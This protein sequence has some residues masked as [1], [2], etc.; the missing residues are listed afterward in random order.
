MQQVFRRLTIAIAGSLVIAAMGGQAFASSPFTL[1]PQRYQSQ[2]TLQDIAQLS[3][4][5]DK[6]SIIILRGQHPELPAR[7]TTQGTRASTITQEQAPIRSELAR[8]HA[9][10]VRSFH[11]VNAVAA[12]ISK[13]EID[14]L[15]TNPAVQA[16]VPDLAIPRA[17][18][19]AAAPAATAGKAASAADLQQLCPSDPATP[20]LEPEALQ[21]MNVEFQPGSGQPAAH[22]LADGTGVRV[23]WIADGID[24]NNPDFQ[25]NGHSIFFDYQDFSGEGPNSPTG[26]A[27]AFGD[28]ASIAAQGSQVYDLS[29]FVNPAHPL[30]PGCTIKIKGVA[31]GAELVGLKTFGN[32]TVPFASLFLQAI[33]WAVNVDNVDVINESFGANVYPDKANDPIALADTAAVA[34]GVTVVVSSGDAGITSTIGTPSDAPGVIGVGA[35]TTLRI[36]RQTTS[37][38]GQLVAGGWISDNIS[39]ISSGGFTQFGPHTVD[40][41]APGD[42]GWSLCSTNRATFA[43]CSDLAGRPTNIQEFG[44]TSQSSPLTAGTAALVIQA[45]ERTHGG[46]R[47]SPDL[48]KRIIVSSATDLGV[49]ASE[50]G[51]GLVDALKAVQTALSIHDANGAPAAMGN[52]LVANQTRLSATA[53]AGTSQ[54]FHVRV[55]NTGAVMQ[56]VRPTVQRLADDLLS[57]DTG[58]LTI[59]P[60]TAPTFV[61]Q[62][63]IPS[64]FVVH[65]FSVP[66]GAQRL[67]GNV[68]WD[69]QSQ[70]NS[71]VRLSVFDPFGRQAIYSLPQGPGGFGHV[72]VRNPAAGIW[73][74]VFWTRKNATV[75]NGSFQFS[76]TTQRFERIGSVSPASRTLA[77]G[78]SATFNVTVRLPVQPGDLS[79][80]LALS[81]GGATDGSIPITLRSLVPLG[82][83]GGAFQGTLTGGNGRMAFGAQTFTFQFDVPRGKSSLDLA[84]RL[85]DPNTNVVGLLVDPSG[86]PLDI[87]TT[88]VGGTFTD[89]MQFFEK[90]PRAGRW[91]AVLNLVNPIDGAHLQEPFSGQITFTG[92]QVLTSGVPHSSSTVIPAGKSVTATVQITNSGVSQKDF[93]VDPRLDQK[94]PLPLLGLNPTTV[95]LPILFGDPQPAF[96]V[97]TDSD[98]FTVVANGSV[99]IQ[100]DVSANFG[101]PD[102][103]GVTVG[104][105]SVARHAAREVAPGVWF[106]LPT[107]IGPFGASGA[108]PAVATVGAAVNTRLFDTSVTSTS[109]D[110]WLSS[111]SASAPFSPLTLAPGATGAI[112]VT[113]TPNA[114]R[115][116][117]VRG[118]L[119]IDTFNGATA[120]GDEI[121]VVPDTYRVG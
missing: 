66:S 104:S 37:Y 99:P 97:P 11:V 38:G 27:E 43:N 34:A 60:A 107:E 17:P 87:Q 101:S 64:A 59:S 69:G 21:R 53:P 71:R 108:P 114:P 45:Y 93:F 78:A 79:A 35:T 68:T 111:I 112:T 88:Q 33:D 80:R 103:E 31:P 106:A 18:S 105:T 83:G 41:V 8:L 32:N 44:G 74:A 84:L 19:E 77:P 14:R 10:D 42:L 2:L 49:V 56:T 24:I 51:A 57:T 15:S 113:F 70:P 98:Q 5:A 9:G 90:T 73:T 30:P 75:F 86:E 52:G 23:A 102:F 92:A 76:F 6:R 22:D 48:V 81:T 109:G 40:V 119:E 36:Y 115:G 12:T 100:M 1:T 72:D 95:P 120:S 4:N 121:V 117:V 3:A 28:A 39:S 26:G 94:A 58:T 46:V 96:L 85:R 82:A 67:D 47:P 50:Q 65:Q 110:L 116:T 20:L 7:G 55:T 118:F 25:R 91:T 54:T 62:A 89:T 63:G 16:V 61:D 29:R 13:A